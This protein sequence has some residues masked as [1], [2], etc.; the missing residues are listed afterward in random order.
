MKET[1]S[2]KGNKEQRLVKPREGEPWAGVFRACR[3]PRP[4]RRWPRE[5]SIPPK[6]A[7]LE[8]FRSPFVAVV[9]TARARVACSV[10]ATIL[11]GDF[12]DRMR[13][14]AAVLTQVTAAAAASHRHRVASPVDEQQHRQAHIR[15]ET[16]QPTQPHNGRQKPRGSFEARPGDRRQP[17]IHA[18]PPPVARIAAQPL[19]ASG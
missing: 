5:P 3:R 9:S 1:A 16:M 6:R 18:V 19:S 10:S 8:Y 7:I 14:A 13:V 4:D 11:D 17:S 15:D 12:Y 2:Q